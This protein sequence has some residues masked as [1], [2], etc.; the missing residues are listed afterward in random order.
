MKALL[1]GLT[2]IIVLFLGGWGFVV[3]SGDSSTAIETMAVE[4]TQ[5]GSIVGAWHSFPAGMVVQFDANG[6]AHFGVDQGGKAFGF[7]AE[8]WMNGE[9]L[10]FMFT[11]YDGEDEACRSAT[12][13]YQIGLAAS[14]AINFLAVDDQCQMRVNILEGNP[15]LGYEPIFHPLR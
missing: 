11:N 15:E 13:V 9:T 2:G 10:S 6:T 14:G 12:G 3:P 4:R 7:E 1:A 5:V 8:T